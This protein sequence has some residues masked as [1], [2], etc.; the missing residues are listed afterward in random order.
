MPRRE[1]EYGEPDFAFCG[2]KVW[3][4]GREFPKSL[5]YWD[6]N[7]IDVTATCDSSN[8]SVEVR[9]VILHLTE[10][11][12]LCGLIETMQRE[13]SGKQ[14]LECMEPYLTF[15]FNVEKTG[16]VDFKLIVK[17]NPLTAEEHTFHFEIDQS[18]FPMF[19]QQCRS[20]L[21]RYPIVGKAT[22]VAG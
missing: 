6:G 12:H 8:A 9:G 4:H 13:L 3:I 19:V 17:P 14:E 20:V 22:N 5:D 1:P 7:W 10:L 15:V 21:K 18:Y 16:A 2:L 11:Q